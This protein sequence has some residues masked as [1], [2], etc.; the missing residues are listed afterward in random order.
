MVNPLFDLCLLGL[1]L[2]SA[3]ADI[4]EFRVPRHLAPDSLHSVVYRLGVF[5][6]AL[7]NILIGKPVE[8]E[9]QNLD[10]KPGQAVSKG[11]V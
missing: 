3:S 7:C 2:R 11:A 8:I 4:A 1:Y 10:L 5:A 6:E 9:I